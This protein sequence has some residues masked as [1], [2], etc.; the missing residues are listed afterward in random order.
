MDWKFVGGEA[1]YLQIMAQIRTAVLT[2]SF[3]PGQRLPSVRDLAMDAQVNP[4]TMQRALH[5]LEL[6]KLLTTDSTNGRFVTDDQA[7]LEALRARQLQELT[8]KCVRQFAAYGVT[9]AEA[10]KLMTQYEQEKEDV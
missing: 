1:V 9:A 7:V 6:E 8:Q 2:G 10:A 3:A 5:E 4:N